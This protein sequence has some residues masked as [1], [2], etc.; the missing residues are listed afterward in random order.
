M[1][2]RTQSVTRHLANV[3]RAHYV[4]RPT[5]ALRRAVSDLRPVT[6]E[7]RFV[8][9]WGAE[10]ACD[11]HES[12]GQAIRRRG[13]FD[14][15]VCETLLRLADAG[16][17]ALDV[18]ANIGQM[19]SLLAYA[20]GSGGVVLAFEPHPDVFA[21]LARNADGWARSPSSGSVR[22]HEMGLSDTDGQLPLTTDVFG[23]NQGSP[24]LEPPPPERPATDVRTVR[25]RRLDEVLDDDAQVGVMKI[26]VEGH[27][28]HAL[29]GAHAMLRSG[30]I[31][32]I[33]FEEHEQPPT[34]VTTLLEEHGYSVFQIGERLRGPSL[35]HLGAPGITVMPG[36]DRNLLATRAPD[37]AVQRLR[38]RGWAI[39]GVGPAGAIERDRRRAAGMP[40]NGTSGATRPAAS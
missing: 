40:V 7:R 25:V 3:A 21:R 9:P 19:T 30:R 6:G 2:P 16:E 28:I 24:T 29:R 14:L 1:L 4:F 36:D 38:A 15:L 34:A 39:Y 23:I 31:R 10:I 5:Q 33:V 26:D 8:L 37:R 12:V 22:L 32:D 35:G 20:L 11:P 17:T 27:E 18:G 13:I